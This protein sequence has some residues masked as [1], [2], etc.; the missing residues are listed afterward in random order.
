VGYVGHDR[1]SGSFREGF[2]GRVVI[3]SFERL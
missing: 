1:G 2:E 3:T